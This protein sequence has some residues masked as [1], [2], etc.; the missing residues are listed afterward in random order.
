MSRLFV[1]FL[2][3]VIPLLQ[4]ACI[5]KLWTKDKPIEERVFDVYG[6]VRSVSE[7]GFMIKTKK[8]E[9]TFVLAATSIKG[10]DFESGAYVHVYYKKLGEENVVTMVVEKVD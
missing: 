9:Q 8:G 1:V 6:E 3:L 7:K 2:L 10:S 5:W 4:P